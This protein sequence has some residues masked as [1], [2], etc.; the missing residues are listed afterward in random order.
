[1]VEGKTYLKVGWDAY[2]AKKGY[3]WNGENIGKASIALFGYDDVGGYSEVQRSYVYDDYGR[4]T[5]SSSPSIQASTKSRS[6]SAGPQRATR[7][8]RTT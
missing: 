7:T 1:M 6:G 4:P 3:G 2:D 5:S 8:T